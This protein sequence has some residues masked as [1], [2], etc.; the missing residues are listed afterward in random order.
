MIEPCQVLS[1]VAAGAPEG[2]PEAI[3]VA[4]VYFFLSRDRLLPGG[5]P[6]AQSAKGQ[7]MCTAFPVCI[8]LA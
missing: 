1:S 3:E 8:R 4:P 7:G 2:R 5:P 6:R